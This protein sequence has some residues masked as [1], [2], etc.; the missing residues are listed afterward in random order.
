MNRRSFLRATLVVSALGLGR[1]AAAKVPT[2]KI[3]IGFPAGGSS[4]TVARLLAELL[5]GS[6]ADVVVVESRT[7]AGGTIAAEAL[8]GAPADG[9]V[10]L[11]SPSTVFT[12]QPHTHPRLPYDPARDF[13]PAAGLALYGGAIAIGPKV[14]AA[15]QS[16]QQW[17]EWA[18]AHPDQASYGSPGAGGGSHF[19]GYQVFRQLGVNAVH[20]PYRGNQPAVSDLIGGQIGAIVTGIPEILPHVQAGKARVLAVTLPSRSRLLP[21]VPTLAEACCSNVTG[22][23]DVMGVYLPARTPSAVVEAVAAAARASTTHPAFL[24]AYEQMAY[25]PFYEGTAAFGARL[26]RERNAWRDVVRASGFKPET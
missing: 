12:L 25:E 8:R 7:G 20:V 18:R 9:S 26:A 22:A 17:A 5:R 1:H 10:L 3:L 14:P 16:L 2:C 13:V 6:Y 19:V 15:V 23:S 4:D 11:V 24:R 21:E